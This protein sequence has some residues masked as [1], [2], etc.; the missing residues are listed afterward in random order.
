[1]YAERGNCFMERKQMK[2]KYFQLL[3]EEMDLV[4]I[5]ELLIRSGDLFEVRSVR[6][7]RDQLHKERMA[8]KERLKLKVVDA[9]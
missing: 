6:A 3:Q 5:E 8:L 1:M 9:V 7:E 4:Q 2:L